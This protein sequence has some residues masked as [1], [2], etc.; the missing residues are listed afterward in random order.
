[1]KSGADQLRDWIRRRS[2]N[3]HEAAELLGVTDVFLSQLLNGHRQPGLA[4]A[5]NIERTTGIAVESWLLTEVSE[6]AGTVGATTGN[7][8]GSTKR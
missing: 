4:N 2:M 6:S 7:R 5:I 1:M 8:R 3:Q